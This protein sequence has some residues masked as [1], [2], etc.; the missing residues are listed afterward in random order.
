MIALAQQ[1]P[2][3]TSKLGAGSRGVQVVERSRLRAL[4]GAAA[5]ARL[6]L[7]SAPAGFGKTTLLAAWLAEPGVR[8]AWLSLDER[9]NDVVRFSR[10]LAAATA[11]LASQG[12]GTNAWE[13][14][15]TFDAD[16]AL[17][18]DPRADRGRM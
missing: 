12:E 4:L 11:C 5:G 2:L 9:D 15:D 13:P 1:D 8:A 10:F 16:L 3:L 14:A 18:A 7:V 17:A 6:V